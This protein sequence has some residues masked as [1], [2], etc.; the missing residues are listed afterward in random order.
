M[1]SNKKL[2]LHFDI[3]G[4]IT[5]I[6]STESGTDRENANMTIARSAFGKIIED[7]W[8]INK[9]YTNN[10]DSISYYDYLKKV[11]KTNYKIRSFLF[12]ND[13]EPGSSLKN[14]LEKVEPFMKKLLF[15]SFY[16]V[17]KEFPNALI[18]FRS[19]GKDIPD[20]LKELNLNDGFEQTAIIT[21]K[22]KDDSVILISSEG[23]I[24]KS[25]IEINKLFLSS[26]RHLAIQ[27]DYSH[28]SNNKR[29]SK[30][31]KTILSD[32]NLFQVFF[33]DNECVNIIGENNCHFIKVNTLDALKNKNYFVEK[34]G[35][36]NKLI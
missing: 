14:L 5:A 7:K 26:K 29:S 2:I 31:G 28:W 23:L 6:D 17:L 8:I 25:F 21:I 3:N 22:Y 32:E 19:F 27:E 12:T 15:E 24:Y 35:L 34:I 33:D 16:Q 9:D 13:N 36:L 10:I 11:D 18:I 20:V 30:F 1:I 4:T